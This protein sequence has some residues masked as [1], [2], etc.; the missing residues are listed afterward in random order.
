MALAMIFGVLII[1]TIYLLTNY[2]YLHVIPIE[3]LR[4][5]DENGIAAFV[6]AETIFGSLGKTL[7]LILFLLCVFSALNSNMVSVPRKYFRMAQE[8][9]FFE[10]AGRVHPKFRTPYMALI[11]TMVAGCVLLLSGSFDLLTDMVIFTSFL[12]YGF[13]AI[14]VLR[15]KSNGTIKIRLIGYPVVPVIFNLSTAI[16]RNP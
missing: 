16:A 15:L 8:G 10:S 4:S 5:I 2:S 9:Y 7:L 14:A 1:M 11:F 13:L 12:F 6:V 3:K